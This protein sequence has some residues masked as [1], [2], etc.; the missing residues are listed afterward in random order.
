MVVMIRGFVVLRL[1]RSRLLRISS[2]SE[3]SSL[4]DLDSVVGCSV[5]CGVGVSVVDWVVASVGG[6]FDRESEEL[7]RSV[8]GRIDRSV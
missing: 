2:K 1:P 3:T 5:V 4:L 8:L 6:G 7:Y